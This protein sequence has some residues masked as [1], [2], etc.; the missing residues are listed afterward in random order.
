MV[1]EGR[2]GGLK[3]WADCST[4]DD[5]QTRAAQL[6]D[7]SPWEG[8]AGLSDGSVEG[9]W[10]LPTKTELYGLANGIE[11]VRCDNM[12]LFTGVQ[13]HYYWSSTTNAF[14]TNYA[15]DV[16]MYYGSVNYYNKGSS[17]YVWPVRGGL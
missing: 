15:W 6:W 16:S 1:K 8:T 14:S 3:P 4:W 10:R 12:R 11:A 17:D 2:L 9:D 5:A 13:P 7:G